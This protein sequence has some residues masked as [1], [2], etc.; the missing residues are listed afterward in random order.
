ML[1]EEPLRLTNHCSKSFAHLDYVY[2]YCRLEKPDGTP[3]EAHHMEVE[4]MNS[5]SSSWRKGFV[6]LAFLQT[7]IL[8]VYGCAVFAFAPPLDDNFTVFTTYRTYLL[9]IPLLLIPITLLIFYLVYKH[10]DSVNI[11]IMQ[12]VSIIA[13]LVILGI[14]IWASVDWWQHCR[15]AATTI[16]SYCY[17]TPENK[18]AWQFMFIFWTLVAL[19]IVHSLLGLLAWYT[20]KTGILG[21]A[22]SQMEMSIPNGSTKTAYKTQVNGNFVSRSLV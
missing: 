7:L 13:G 17:V 14:I 1:E 5:A 6:F 4:R 15:A 21:D 20:M 12:V 8:V 16:F 22:Y 2:G 19:F 18:L 11:T 3:T 10:H 9:L